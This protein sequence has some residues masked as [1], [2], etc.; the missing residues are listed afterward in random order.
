M[1][2]WGIAKDKLVADRLVDEELHELAYR[3]IESG[4]RRDGL[5]A[6]AIVEGHGDEAATKIAYLRLL[7]QRLRDERYVVEQVEVE[8]LRR[9]QQ[10]QYER[11]ANVEHPR[12]ATPAQQ[13]HAPKPAPKNCF[14]CSHYFSKGVWDK[15]KG[16]CT[17]HNKK[18][19]ASDVCE[20]F[21]RKPASSSS[22]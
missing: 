13:P 14:N 4:A 20:S 21:S 6:K 16:R 15:S 9:A 22:T 7:V 11:R 1:S 10:Q 12:R 5:W 3:E 2:L 17:L 19:Y 8:A 18:V